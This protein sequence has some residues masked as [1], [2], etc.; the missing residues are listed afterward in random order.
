MRHNILLLFAIVIT[1]S[2]STPKYTYHFDHY[3]Y[4]AGK[5]KQQIDLLEEKK[6]L[7]NEFHQ[8][9]LVQEE[10][11]L[12]STSDEVIVIYEESKSYTTNLEAVAAAETKKQD[13]EMS[14][15]EKREVRKKFRNDLKEYKTAKK[16]G[17]EVRA[18]Q[19]KER[20]TGYTRMGVILIIAGLVLAILSLGSVINSIG[21]LMVLAGVIFI[22]VD[23]L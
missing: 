23:L 5:R 9:V 11:L 8:A 14:K 17:D 16:S 19:A 15:A 22:L 7:V 21:G 4:N 18:E 13:A 10:T 12:A 3:D 20:L 1:A 2:C 6:I